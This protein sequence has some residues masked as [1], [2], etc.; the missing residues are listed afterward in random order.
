M[1][2]DRALQLVFAQLGGSVKR[3]F[4]YRVE[5]ALVL[6]RAPVCAAGAGGQRDGNDTNLD[7]PNQHR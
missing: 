2:P 6:D 5:I 4:R 1:F 7:R 3:A